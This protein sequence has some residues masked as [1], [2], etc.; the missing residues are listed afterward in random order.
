MIEIKAAN[1]FVKSGTE[2]SLV[3]GYSVTLAHSLIQKNGYFVVS[4]LKLLDEKLPT[5][6]HIIQ[7]H[8]VDKEETRTYLVMPAKSVKNVITSWEVKEVLEEISIV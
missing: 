5:K 6:P 2:E 7:G 3:Y 1:I 4:I 8:W